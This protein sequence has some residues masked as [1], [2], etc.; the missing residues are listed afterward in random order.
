MELSEKE[1]I[2][3]NALREAHDWLHKHHGR[4][5]EGH[6]VVLHVLATVADIERRQAKQHR[7]DRN[8]GNVGPI[9]SRPAWHGQA[10]HTLAERREIAKDRLQY[11]IDNILVSD[12]E[13]VLAN[14]VNCKFCA[15]LPSQRTSQADWDVLKRIAKG[16]TER[17]IAKD[18]DVHHSAISRMKSR[19]G[20]AAD[21]WHVVS[22]LMPAPIRQG[23]VWRNAA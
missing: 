19:Q 3:G 4:K 10:I 12:D 2:V 18:L 15:A 20:C 6:R 21:I 14:A 9:E 22:H 17:A 11:V 13:V 16:G 23:R 1:R 8:V 7:N 5:P